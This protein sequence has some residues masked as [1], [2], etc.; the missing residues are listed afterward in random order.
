[1]TPRDETL[2]GRSTHAEIGHGY[3]LEIALKCS[4]SD[5]LRAMMDTR[6]H[7]PSFQKRGGGGGVSPHKGCKKGLL[8]GVKTRAPAMGTPLLPPPPVPMCV[9]N[10][11]F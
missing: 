10:R 11:P 4:Q 1:M 8:G 2:S 7:G 3:L 6:G 9:C 5:A